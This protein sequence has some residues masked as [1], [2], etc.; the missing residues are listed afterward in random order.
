MLSGTKSEQA[1]H[2]VKLLRLRNSGQASGQRQEASSGL[3][4][5]QRTP[6]ALSEREVEVRTVQGVD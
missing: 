3:H 6:R 4:G 1:G 5:G 2:T